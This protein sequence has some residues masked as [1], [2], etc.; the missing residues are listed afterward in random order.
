MRVLAMIDKRLL[1]DKLQVKLVK[2]KGDYGGFVYDEPFV[3]SPVRFDRNLATAGKD[4][5]RQEIK[6]SVIFIYPKYCQNAVDRTWEDAI[7]I[8]G[9]T[10][11]TVNKVV[12]IYYPHK[13]KVFC[14]E[15]EVI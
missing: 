6:P 1:I 4:N 8:D 14:F 3:L 7:V 5:A 15:V 10:E 2:D 13:N 11:Y 12:P 9:D